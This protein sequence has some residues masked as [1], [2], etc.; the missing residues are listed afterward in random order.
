MTPRAVRAPKPTA[1][2]AGEVT[3]KKQQAGLEY[4][5][6]AF[7]DI[8]YA[9]ILA[10]ASERSGLGDLKRIVYL[11]RNPRRSIAAVN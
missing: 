3:N 11:V 9:A 4:P 10:V 2:L 7:S 6:L 1:T 8:S 5:L